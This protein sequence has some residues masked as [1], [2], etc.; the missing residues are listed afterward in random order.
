VPATEPLAALALFIALLAGA[1][2]RKTKPL[3]LQD[4]EPITTRHVNKT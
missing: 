1:W 2:C 3:G 4:T